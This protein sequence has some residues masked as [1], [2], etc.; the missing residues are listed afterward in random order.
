MKLRAVLLDLGETLVRFSRPWED[1]SHEQIES[2]YK[3]LEDSGL[4]VDFLD[5]ARTFVRVYDEAAARSNTFK[6]EISMEEILTKSLSKFNVKAISRNF[7]ETVSRQY[8]TPEIDAWQLYPD[9]VDTLTK[10]AEGF[11]LGLISNAKSD[12]MVHQ[13]LLKYDLQKFFDT[14]ITSAALRIRKPRPDIFSKALNDLNVKAP[15]SVFVGDSL[16][17]D[18]SGARNVGMHSIFIKRK[19][20]EDSSFVSPEATVSSLKEALDTITS[21]STQSKLTWNQNG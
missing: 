5:F 14:V 4:P 18:I 15:E 19:T 3:C 7:I 16:E 2:A 6:V 13:I 17:A 1:V 11:K 9:A 10:L 21:W 20:P 8:F 12:W